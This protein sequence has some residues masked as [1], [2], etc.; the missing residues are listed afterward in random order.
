MKKLFL[1]TLL[2][3]SL[4]TQAQN[5]ITHEK[6]DSITVA[7]NVCKKFYA[8]YCNKILIFYKQQGNQILLTNEYPLIFRLSEELTN[9]DAEE[10]TTTI[11][12]MEFISSINFGKLL[13]TLEQ[14]KSDTTP[15]KVEIVNGIPT[16]NTEQSTFNITKGNSITSSGYYLVYSKRL[17]ILNGGI[18]FTNNDS[19]G[20]YLDNT[21]CIFD[22]KKYVYKSNQWTKQ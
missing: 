8:D 12:N 7:T 20:K 9:N 10:K 6:K 14:Q 4:L 17:V 1:L 2:L 19:Q 18:I 21:E 11:N 22:G 3:C 5:L 15:I 16:P 13:F